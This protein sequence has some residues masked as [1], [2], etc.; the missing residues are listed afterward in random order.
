[1][2]TDKGNDYRINFSHMSKNEA[3]NVF[4]STN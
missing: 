4:K 2:V 3:I 1:M